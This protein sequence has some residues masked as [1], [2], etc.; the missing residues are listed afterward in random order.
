MNPKQPLDLLKKYLDGKCSV[1]EEA[2]IHEWYDSLGKGKLNLADTSDAEQLR[3]ERI[4]NVV[5]QRTDLYNKTQQPPTT[6]A[7][8]VWRYAAA[9]AVTL[10]ILVTSL[11][12]FN[13]DDAPGSFAINA[14]EVVNKINNASTEAEVTLPD[15]STVKLTP[16][17]RLSFPEKFEASVREV[18]LEGEGFFEVVRD[19]SRPFRVHT[20]K[21]TTHVLGTSFVIR[22]LENVDTIQ[23]VVRTGKVSVY[24]G[25]ELDRQ[26]DAVI[27]TPNQ[28][29]AYSKTSE[30]IIRSIIEDPLPIVKNSE[31]AS[32][33][34]NTPVHEILK[35]LSIR[36]G[37]KIRTENDKILSCP[38]TASFQK[39]SLHAR[40][41]MICGAIGASY[42]MTD[43]AIVISGGNCEW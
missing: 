28:Q 33:F 15:G 19:E 32:S 34:E 9:A 37:I 2:L 40:L 20:G 10:A 31:E 24:E 30:K 17:S 4:Y 41:E 1:E 7:T 42:E 5:R 26:H 3:K 23:V 43:E 14:N 35:A 8:F 13:A 18:V 39:H 6:N 25:H 38:V 16:G 11:L 12:Y 36:Y 22:A 29:V 27:L 21:L